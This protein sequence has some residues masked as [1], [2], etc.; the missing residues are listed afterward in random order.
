MYWKTAEFQKTIDDVNFALG[1]ASDQ[2]NQF[3]TGVPQADFSGGVGGAIKGLGQHLVG[4]YKQKQIDQKAIQQT[5]PTLTQLHDRMKQYIPQK[6]QSPNYGQKQQLQQAYDAFMKYWNDF[7]QTY[8]HQPSEA[9]SGPGKPVD[10][11]WANLQTLMNDVNEWGN[12]L[13]P[14]KQSEKKWRNQQAARM[15]LARA[16]RS[17]RYNRY[18]EPRYQK[19]ADLENSTDLDAFMAD[20]GTQNVQQLGKK[21]N[22]L[23]KSDPGAADKLLRLIDPKKA[24]AADAAKISNQNWQAFSGENDEEQPPEKKMQLPGAR[25]IKAMKNRQ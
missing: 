18:G 12:Y 6:G 8:G 13:D 10:P 17:S 14:E 22:D 7:T 1:E 3:S 4:K 19:P 20:L 5:I 16:G 2:P 24:K 23:L 21:I 25:N 11:E 9:T 15:Q